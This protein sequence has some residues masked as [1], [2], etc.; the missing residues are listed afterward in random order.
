MLHVPRDADGRLNPARAEVETLFDGSAGIVRHPVADFDAQNHLLRLPSGQARGGG[1]AAVLASDVDA[2]RRQRPA[3]V[4]RGPLPRLRPGPAAR[5]RTGVHVHPLQGA[6]PLLGAAGLRAVPHAARRNRPAPP[7]LR[8]HQRM[9]SGRHA[10]RADSLDPLGVS[11]QGRRL[12][13]HALGHPPRRRPPRA[14]LR[15]RHALLLRPW[16]R[17]ARQ[18]GNR[19][20][21]HLA[22]RPPGAD[23][24][25]RPQ[26]GAVRH[27]GHHQH[28]PRHPAAV[29]DGPVAPRDLP[30]SRADLARSFPGQPQSRPAVALGLVCHRPF[31]EPGTALSRPGDQQQASLAAA[32]PPAPAGVAGDARPGPRATGARPVHGPG[33]LRRPRLDRRP[34]PGEVPAGF[35]GGAGPA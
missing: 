23:R 6:V 21:A 4:D 12:R 18:P 20:H 19:L 9:G 33:R 27:R 13:P 29:P 11:G 5:R 25:D 1:L 2:R 26:P 3:P 31:R 24:A 30:R 15:Q 14:G 16:A 35:P 17:G 28:H 8:Q 32:R 10:R 22:R 7:F 34:R